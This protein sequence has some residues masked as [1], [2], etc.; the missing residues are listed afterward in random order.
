MAEA[1]ALEDAQD[2]A[3]RS[4]LL[5]RKLFP[6]APQ[7]HIGRFV[8]QERI[9]AGAMGTVYLGLDEQLHRAVAIKVLRASAGASN[10][11]LL[12]EARGLAKIAHPNVVTV[13]E[14]GE[15][16]EQFYVAMEYVH[17]QTLATWEEGR[18]WQECLSAYRAAGRGLI[19]VHAA[20]LVHRDF[21]PA[22]VLV[23]DDGRVQVADFGLVRSDERED[24]P[25]AG[26]ALLN[27]DLTAFGT[28]L[29]T[30][31]YMSPEQ[32]RGETAD[33]RSDQFSFCVALFE[34]VTGTRPFPG[35]TVPQLHAAIARGAAAA[36]RRIPTWLD[37]AL[38]RG[39]SADPADRHSDMD[40]LVGALTPPRRRSW[41]AA[42]GIAAVVVAGVAGI[43]LAVLEPPS[44][45]PA[46][47][48]AVDSS[49]IAGAQLVTQARK[50]LVSDPTT[51]ALLLLE[52]VPTTPG[53]SQAARDALSGPI[54]Q[55]SLRPEHILYGIRYSLDGH[56]EAADREGIFHRW[57]GAAAEAQPR[58]YSTLG[59]ATA[60]LQVSDVVRRV[61]DADAR[62]GP[63]Y[64][65]TF[66]KS[67]VLRWATK[68]AVHDIVADGSQVQWPIPA[69]GSRGIR[70]TP[71][72]VLFRLETSGVLHRI[73]VETQKATQIARNV[74]AFSTRDEEVIAGKK[75]GWLGVWTSG[76]WRELD[77]PKT[78]TRGIIV[79]SARPWIV[80]VGDDKASVWHVD[81]PSAHFDIPGRWMPSG[82]GFVGRD[83]IWLLN[84]QR[85]PTLWDL[86]NQRTLPFGVPGRETTGVAHYGF[87]KAATSGLDGRLHHWNLAGVEGQVLVQQAEGGI[88]AGSIDH[89]RGRLATAGTDGTVR[90]VE[91]GGERKVQT[92]GTGVEANFYHTAFSEDGLWLA[93][94]AGDGTARIW[95][96]ETGGPPLVFDGHATWAYALSF[97]P[98]GKWLA[99]GDRDGVVRHLPTA[100]GEPRVLGAHPLPNGSRRIHAI[101]HNPAGTHVISASKNGSIVAFPTDGT[102]HLTVTMEEYNSIVAYDANDRL[103]TVGTRGIVQRWS[104][105]PG[106]IV[107][108]YDLES[109]PTAWAFAHSGDHL[110]VA[111]A[112]RQVQ[113]WDVAVQDAPAFQLPPGDAVSEAVVFDPESQRLAVGD[114][115]G[116][117]RIVDMS[118]E[119][120]WRFTGHT[121]GIRFLA[122]YEDDLLSASADGTIRRWETPTSI[123]G[124]AALLR[125]RTHSCLTTGERRRFL[126]ES[127]SKAMATATTCLEKRALPPQDAPR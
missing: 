72:G 63:P 80:A 78:G 37:S 91:L 105:V 71:D 34:A 2:E 123:A 126:G 13:Y 21:K 45:E 103:M 42:A 96:L 114:G 7:V 20:G 38:R 52:A 109:A 100:G 24:T 89:A 112:N 36:A 106:K 61:A 69:A 90:L 19:A 125:S 82:W 60:G 4:A 68:A 27:T 116:T 87:T 94:G 110:A 75:S 127:K 17:G 124:L 119:E 115:T 48:P 64:A 85:G 88:W 104:D 12:R 23:G 122:F 43:G 108:R 39:L 56:L 121:R 57:A 29:G 14:A 28:L 77:G 79:D 33:A 51:A 55:R 92:L 111:T 93:A 113:V 66:L 22:N 1:A 49:A 95:N 101:V 44:P 25:H 54:I 58:P 40:A 59:T 76:T 18:S 118:G 86:R 5:R 10:H 70:L 9:G 99:T 15:V 65:Y 35:E 67:G 98:D 97:S 30:P 117:I 32:L 73:D 41:R 47:A 83:K 16:G 53:W 107:A 31:A 46:P 50:R 26:I 11:R 84:G 8:L 62:F 3:R 102:E 81:E 6:D 120:L 74:T